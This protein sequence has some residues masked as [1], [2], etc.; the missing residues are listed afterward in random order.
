M[1]KKIKPLFIGL[2][3]A[4]LLGIRYLSSTLQSHSYETNLIFLKSFNSYNVDEPTAVEYELL[5][6]KISELNPGYIGISIMCSFY[7]N[8]AK[9]IA[10]DLHNKFPAIKILLGGA[11]P[12]LFPEECLNFADVVFRGESEDAIVEFTDA[13]ENGRPYD[14]IENIAFKVKDIIL[15]PMRPL[16]QDLDRLPHPDF[17]GDNIYYINNDKVLHCDPEVQSFSY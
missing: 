6:N 15:N 10:D 2:Y 14:G 16:I 1:Q 12:T 9:K 3:D 17:G 5:Y 11:Y 13:L 8:V 4:K 7:L